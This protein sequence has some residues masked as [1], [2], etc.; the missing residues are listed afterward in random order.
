MTFTLDSEHAERLWAVSQALVRWEQWS[1]KDGCFR[2]QETR[3]ID[4]HNSYTKSTAGCAAG[5][6]T[7]V[8][9]RA[10]RVKGESKH[11]CV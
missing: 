3:V 6:F 4:F 9:I 11:R 7:V 1:G 5:T 8:F 10:D 2:G